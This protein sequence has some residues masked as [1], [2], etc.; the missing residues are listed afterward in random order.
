MLGALTSLNQHLKT[1]SQVPRNGLAIYVGEVDGK[2]LVFSFEPPKPIGAFLYLC[3]RNF[4]TEPLEEMLVDDVAIGVAV[5]QGSGYDFA[6]VTNGRVTVV[7]RETVDLPSK[8][9]RGGQSALRFSRLNDE[10]RANYLTK[11]L[12][13]LHD[14]FCPLV[15][16]VATVNVTKLVVAGAG[17]LKASLMTHPGLKRELRDIAVGPF[18]VQYGGN[19]GVYAAL[20]AAGPALADVAVLEE[21]RVLG[22][23]FDHLANDTGKASYGPMLRE[24]W[25]A[26]RLA[27]LLVAK[28]MDLRA[29]VV[30][31]PRDVALSQYVGDRCQMVTLACSTPEGSQLVKGFGGVGGIRKYRVVDVGDFDGGDGDVE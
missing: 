12:A 19:S 4:H 13:R 29:D 30:G 21:R 18:E 11:V 31:G 22:E 7:A 26:D 24:D 1:L 28:D 17:P 5:V 16:N 3:D 6:V 23:F 20:E 9:R 2:R 14:T 10:K 15:N 8:T 27:V 25:A